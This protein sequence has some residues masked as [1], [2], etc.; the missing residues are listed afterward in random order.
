MTNAR[1][2][3]ADLI[4]KLGEGWAIAQTTLGYERGGNSLARVTTLRRP[5]P[6]SLVKAARRL[7]R[8]RPPADRRPRGARRSW[9]DLGRARGPALRLAARPHPA[10]ARRAPRRERL[11]HQAL[12]LGVREAL[13][14]AGAGD[15]RPVRP[16]HRGRAA[17]SVDLEIDTAGASTGTWAYAFLWSRAGTIYAGLLRDPEERHRRARARPAQGSRAPTARGPAR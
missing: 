13:H 9:A 16:A 10:R 3:Q 8:A 4:G 17:P 12:V 15:P 6:T 7:K 14:G 1:V 2:E 5:V 11:A